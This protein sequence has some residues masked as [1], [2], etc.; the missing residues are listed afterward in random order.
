[1]PPTLIGAPRGSVQKN[2]IASRVGKSGAGRARRNE[3]VLP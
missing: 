2:G 3:I 1:M